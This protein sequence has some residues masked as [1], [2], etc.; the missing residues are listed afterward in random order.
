MIR[1]DDDN[2][3]QFIHFYAEEELT[4]D[5]RLI[6]LHKDW[7]RVEIVPDTFLFQEGH[8]EHY[9][10]AKY[11]VFKFAGPVGWASRCGQGDD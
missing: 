8:A 7:S 10:V 9:E 4:N 1:A 11:G 3:A 2:I 5:E 6:K